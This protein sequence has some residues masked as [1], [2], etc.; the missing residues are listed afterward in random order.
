[1]LQSLLQDRFK[2]VSHTEEREMR[3]RALVLANADGRLGPD[4]RR[5]GDPCTTADSDEARKQ[6]PA[7]AETSGRG[8]AVSGRCTDLTLLVTSFNLRARDPRFSELPVLDKTGLTGKVTYDF[9]YVIPDGIDPFTA[10]AD[11]LEEQLG[12]ELVPDRGLI[13]VRVID[14]IEQPS[15]N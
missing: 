15:E 10:M 14:S 7:R 1:M 3:V 13:P 9:R 12:L 2:L 6:F 4:M 5:M 8:G 11:A